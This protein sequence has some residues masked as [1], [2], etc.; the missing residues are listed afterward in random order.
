MDRYGNFR[1]IVFDYTGWIRCETTDLELLKHL[2]SDM[3][4]YYKQYMNNQSLNIG[5][6][7]LD[8][9]SALQHKISHYIESYVCSNGWEPYAYA[10]KIGTEHI[11]SFRKKY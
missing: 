7:T 6:L 9:V 1:L 3:E 8:K 11:V 5:I 2:G 4:Q 10:G